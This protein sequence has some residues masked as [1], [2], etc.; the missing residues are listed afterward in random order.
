VIPSLVRSAGYADE[1]PLVVA[2][3][4]SGE[5]LVFA[6]G[7]AEDGTPFGPGSLVYAASLA[8]QFTG[9]CAALLEREGLLDTGAS[10][11]EWLPELPDWSER[12]RVRHLLYH[13]AGLPSVWPQ[14]E[15]TGTTDWTSRGVLAALAT[16]P[17]PD[18]E[19]GSAYAYSN[20]GYVCLAL[21]VERSS[22]SAL[23]AF[24]Q[25]RIFEPLGMR[26]TLFW[27]GPS[28][29]PPGAA[30]APDPEEPAPLSV[31]DGGL[32][33]SVRD[34]LRWNDAIFEDALGI[35]ARM[36]TP[37]SLDDG[38]PLEYAWGVRTLS[39]SGEVVHSH[40]GSYGNAA[41]KLVRLPE[42]KTGFVVLAADGSVE[43]VVFLSD[44]LQEYLRGRSARPV[45]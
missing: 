21:V 27:T 44:A 4:A 38:T 39:V 11:R 2:V 26:D 29:A 6:Q 28:P 35:T 16:T 24:A 30:A 8:K 34:L 12:V 32:W 22:G 45:S 1:T 41:A 3:G 14:M 5:P 19:P 23:D 25:A 18:R 17:R 31:G 15:A 43:R 33:T 13:T 42:R 36:H 10:I 7:A 40:G 37:G 9:A 20:E